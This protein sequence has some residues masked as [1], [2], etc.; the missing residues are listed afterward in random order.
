MGKADEYELK[1]VYHDDCRMNIMEDIINEDN[2]KFYEVKFKK[3]RNDNSDEV[4]L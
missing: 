1:F 2:E 3:W 4:K